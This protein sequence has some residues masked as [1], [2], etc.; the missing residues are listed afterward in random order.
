MS[1]QNSLHRLSEAESVFSGK[2]DALDAVGLEA[3]LHQQNEIFKMSAEEVRSQLDEA[4]AH[5]RESIGELAAAYAAKRQA[6]ET[7]FRARKLAASELG[8]PEPKSSYPAISELEDI[9]PDVTQ[10]ELPPVIAKSENDATFKSLMSSLENINNGSDDSEERLEFSERL[11]SIAGE[12]IDAIDRLKK[13]DNVL[14][15]MGSRS[16]TVQ[17]IASHASDLTKIQD[18]LHEV[19]V[20]IAPVEDALITLKNDR[21]VVKDAMKQ[22][23]SRAKKA[24]KAEVQAREDGF[25]VRAGEMQKLAASAKKTMET[26]SF[27]KNELTQDIENISRVK[28]DVNMIRTR[29]LT[30]VVE[31]NNF[32]RSVGVDSNVAN[33]AAIMLSRMTSELNMLERE[34]SQTKAIEA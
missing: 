18:A 32:L 17:N 6:D 24:E 27:S 19:A 29:L 14:S 11:R 16:L 15:D 31:G 30:L 20:Q 9:E 23:K 7:V 8:M 28:H 10:K 33:G 21:R 25:P 5:Y 22:W 3:S 26:M 34:A 13:L 2:K 12:E 1:E 4:E